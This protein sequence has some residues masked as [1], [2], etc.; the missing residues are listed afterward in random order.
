MGD[1]VILIPTVLHAPVAPINQHVDL[2]IGFRAKR[3]VDYSKLA[4]I[5]DEDDNDFI[6]GELL[7]GVDKST[8]ATRWFIK[9]TL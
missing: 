5:G 7:L 1:R 8:E 2:L 9:I 4:N 6:N 3:A